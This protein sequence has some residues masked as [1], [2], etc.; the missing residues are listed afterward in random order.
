VGDGNPLVTQLEGQISQM[1]PNILNNIQ[2]QIKN[3]ELTRGSYS[4]TVENSIALLSGI[5]EKEKELLQISRDQNIRNGIYSFLLQKKEESLLSYTN[6]N[7]DSKV[8]NYAKADDTPVSPKRNVIYFAALILGLLMP[9][10]FVNGREILN[11]KILYRKEIESL[12]SIPVIGE[13]VYNKSKSFTGAG[14]RQ[15]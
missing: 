10:V 5:P 3:L 14:T 12:T 4:A 8:V 9:I 15:A 11:N 13:I 2:T 6:S 1:K 7:T